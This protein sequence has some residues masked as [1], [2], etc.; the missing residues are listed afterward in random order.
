MPI[1]KRMVTMTNLST[2][3]LS[4]SLTIS[5]YA[6]IGAMPRWFRTFAVEAAIY[7]PSWLPLIKAAQ[8]GD[9]AALATC[10]RRWEATL[11]A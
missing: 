3:A 7:A 9:R 2:L 11:A 10:Q 8:C 6:P 4:L 1:A 5:T